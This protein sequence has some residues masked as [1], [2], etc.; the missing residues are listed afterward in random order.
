MAMD[1]SNLPQFN[2]KASYLLS[3]EK[4]LLLKLNLEQVKLDASLLLF[5]RLLIP[6]QFILKLL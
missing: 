5:C 2:R 6:L 1:L 4:I 3:K